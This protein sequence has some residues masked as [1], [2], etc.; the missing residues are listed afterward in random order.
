VSKTDLPVWVSA[1]I[2][3]A[4]VGDIIEIRR[5]D[6]YGETVG[7]FIVIGITDDGVRRLDCQETKPEPLGSVR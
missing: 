1:K 2:D 5:D 7:W 3:E 4:G 6:R